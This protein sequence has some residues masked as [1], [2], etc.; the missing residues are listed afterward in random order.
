LRATTSEIIAK[1]MWEDI[2]CKH[3]IFEQLS[4]NKGPKNKN[5]AERFAAIY[6]IIRVII[7]AYN[8]K[9]NGMIE[10][11]HK[12]VINALAKMTKNGISK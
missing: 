2:I 10:K 9:A 6:G 12:S 1:F 7:S 3:R 11:G 5:L 8:A 4:I